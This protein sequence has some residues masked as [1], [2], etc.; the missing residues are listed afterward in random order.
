MCV[1]YKI[2]FWNEKEVKRLF[3]DFLVYNVLIETA[4]IKY[5][6]NIH[7]LHDLPFY[8]ELPPNQFFLCNF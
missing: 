4:Y 3:Q 6:E 8:D 1:L 7:L 2:S 5:G